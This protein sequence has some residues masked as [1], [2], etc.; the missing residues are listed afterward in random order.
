MLN[1]S[2]LWAAGLLF[3]VFAAGS[4]VGGAAS[5]AWG[6]GDDLDDSRRHERD[7]RSRRGG[8]A[9]RLEQDLGLS[10]AQRAKVDSILERQQAEMRALWEEYRPRFDTLR[11]EVRNQ[12]MEILDEEQKDEYRELIDRSDRRRDRESETQSN[13]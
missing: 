13:N 9:D 3:A 7:G 12:I 2:K 10:A 6:V 5:A 4:A 1:R 8:Y 11:L